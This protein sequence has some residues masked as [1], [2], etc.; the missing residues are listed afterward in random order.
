MSNSAKKWNELFTYNILKED[1]SNQQGNSE[2][3]VNW[4]NTFSFKTANR[5]YS[6]YVTLYFRGKQVITYANTS[7]RGR[8]C[9]LY[10]NETT[11]S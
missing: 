9:L 4:N 8:V 6:T 2:N 5:P 10:E 11:I 3:N 7:N 1:Q